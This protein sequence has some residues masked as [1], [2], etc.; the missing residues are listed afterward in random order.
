MRLSLPADWRK[1]IPWT[2]L[3]LAACALVVSGIV[4]SEAVDVAPV[5]VLADHNALP[6]MIETADAPEQAITAPPISLNLPINEGLIAFTP[7]TNLVVPQNGSLFNLIQPE[8]EPV[9]WKL[10]DD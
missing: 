9:S 6:V 4:Y 10:G 8:S 1:Q 5:N 7:D 3:V 2:Y